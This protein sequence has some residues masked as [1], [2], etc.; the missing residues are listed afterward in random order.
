MRVK[1]LNMELSEIR[2]HFAKDIPKEWLERVDAELRPHY[3]WLL[4]GGEAYCDSCGSKFSASR[5]KEKVHNKRDTCPC[6]GESF[7][8]RKSWVGQNPAKRNVLSY[9]FAKSQVAPNIIT[10]TAVFS[11]YGYE[12]GE[13]PWQTEPLRLVDAL[14]VFVIGEGVAYASPWRLY[15]HDI[16]VK[17]GVYFYRTINTILLYKH[18]TG[19]IARHTFSDR[20]CVYDTAWKVTNAVY[21]YDDYDSLYEAAEGTTLG[22]TI[23]AVKGALEDA[24]V[25]SPYIHSLIDMVERL[26][27]H[28]ASFEIVAKMGFAD[29]V[30]KAFYNNYKLNHLINLRG[31][32]VAQIFKGQLTKE[33]KRY[34]FKNGATYSLLEIWQKLRRM[35]QPIPAEELVKLCNDP[36]IITVID[37]AT[38]YKLKIKKILTYIAKQQKLTKEEWPLMVYA[39]YIR[40]CENLAENYNMGHIYNLSNEAVLFP[41]NLVQAHQTTIELVN[42]ERDRKA[43]LDFERS[44]GEIAKGISAIEK[45]YKKLLPKLKKKYS[46]QSDGY[47]IVIP[48]NLID[49][50]REGIAMH[51]CVGGYKERVASGSTQVVYIRKLD[52]MDKSFGTMEIST[53]ET[54]IQARGKY[55]KDLPEDAEVFVKKF[56]REVLEPLRTIAISLDGVA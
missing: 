34:F 24:L 41:Q 55:N 48:P 14:Y 45:K 17:D 18:P 2:S 40:D 10:C 3:I 32:N 13:A 36:Y 12:A 47:V 51:N 43:M 35:G 38:K 23:D 54:I 5:L 20:G 37:F 53:R 33:D 15:P 29:A 19:F 11:C 39:D 4:R 1:T 22:Y 49:L 9:H 28:P 7:P 52:D 27:R 26:A 16:R 44:R 30:V 50:H 8:V 25:V 56:E 31:K 6:C 42:M 21:Q 46:Y